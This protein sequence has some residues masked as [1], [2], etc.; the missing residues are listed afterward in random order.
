MSKLVGRILCA[1]GHHRW[2]WRVEFIYGSWDE[3]GRCGAEREQARFT[4]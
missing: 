4:E 1:L 2:D 3:C